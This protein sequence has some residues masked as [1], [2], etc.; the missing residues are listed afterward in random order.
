MG[1]WTVKQSQWVATGPDKQMQDTGNVHTI[2]FTLDVNGKLCHQ[3][4]CLRID[5]NI[6][7]H[8]AS[9]LSKTV[10]GQNLTKRWQ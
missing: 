4:C 2:V 5:G 1:D 10:N 3:K 7:G 9:L 6:A 8:C